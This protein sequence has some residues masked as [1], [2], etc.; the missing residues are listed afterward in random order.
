MPEAPMPDPS[1]P[2][3]GTAQN[4]PAPD[5]ECAQ[6]RS[7]IAQLEQELA[8]SRRL[9]GQVETERDEYR[10]YVHAQIRASFTE[11]ELRALAEPVDEET[12][13]PLDNFFGE[14]E[15]VVKRAKRVS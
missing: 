4:G 3:S 15:E 10:R 13:K 6:L 8:A 14:L 1:N 5:P 12:C 2:E 11:A 9:L 7:R